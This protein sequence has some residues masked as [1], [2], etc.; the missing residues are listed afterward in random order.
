MIGKRY[1]YDTMAACEQQLWWYKCL[2][3]QTLTALENN[4]I[5]TKATILDA[6][7][8]TGG[9]LKY[10]KDRNYQQLV[11]FDLSTDA[12]EYAAETSGFPIYRHSLTEAHTDLANHQFDA[13]ISNDTFCLLPAP[14]DQQALAIQFTHVKPG[15]ILIFNLAA[16]NAFGGTHDVSVDM[17]KR[18]DRAGIRAILPEGA[19]VVQMVYWPFL[20][21]PLIFLFRWMQRL[22]LRLQPGKTFASDVKMPPVWQNK[23]FYKITNWEIRHMPKKPWGSSLFT[24]IRKKK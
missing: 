3:E 20:L 1:E 11:G 12:V 23:L 24:V 15:G 9:M 5:G 16:L 14:L 7:C 6:G 19:E 10:L 17:E 22:Q 2:H 4:G 8:G 21:S 13:V 18:Y